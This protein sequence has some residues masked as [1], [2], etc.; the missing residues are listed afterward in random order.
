MDFN[1]DGKVCIQDLS[2]FEELFTRNSYK[3]KG[4]ISHDEENFKT[5]DSACLRRVESSG[6]LIPKTSLKSFRRELSRKRTIAKKGGHDISD[7]EFKRMSI[8]DN[9]AL[10]IEMNESNSLFNSYSYSEKSSLSVEVNTPLEDLDKP[11][12]E[13]V[14]RIKCKVTWDNGRGRKL[15][16]SNIRNNSAMS[17][18]KNFKEDQ[19]QLVGKIFGQRDLGKEMEK[20]NEGNLANNVVGKKFNEDYVRVDLDNLSDNF[21]SLYKAIN[22]EAEKKNQYLQTLENQLLTARAKKIE[23]DDIDLQNLIYLVNQVEKFKQDLFF[24]GGFTLDIFNEIFSLNNSYNVPLDYQSFAEF[25]DGLD[26]KCKP[27]DQEIQLFFRKCFSFQK[28][29]GK[30]SFIDLFYFLIPFSREY[31]T[32]EKSTEAYKNE[33]YLDL[34]N[35]IFE[36]SFEIIVRFRVILEMEDN[37]LGE[38]FNEKYDLL[39]D[40]NFDFGKDANRDFQLI[41]FYTG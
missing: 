34:I 3:I 23:I 33:E 21:T 22:K 15:N 20:E 11:K 25:L 18:R 32:I 19:N 6:I 38:I 7:Y 8:L 35:Y 9:S 30:P 41:K 26:Q 5:K 39:P 37:I 40:K 4:S 29:K 13:D 28:I 17:K 36:L 1:N 2:Q 24:K 16:E 27:M 12:E 14:K 10:F 31:C